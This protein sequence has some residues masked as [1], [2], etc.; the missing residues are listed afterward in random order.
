MAGINENADK[1]NFSLMK[2]SKILNNNKFDNWFIGYGTLLGIVRNNSCIDGDDDVDIICNMNDYQKL[3]EI[4]LKEKYELDFGHGINQ[5]KRIIKT[6]ASS[7]SAS[8]DFYMTEVD[9]NG[10]FNDIWEGI[11]WSN[12]YEEKTKEFI[13][14][15][16]NNTTL[17]L[18][19]D[20]HRKLRKIYGIFWR[21][22]QKNKG[23]RDDAKKNLRKIYYLVLPESLRN[24][25]KKIIKKYN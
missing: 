20:F 17:N 10:N 5:S 9:H 15:T 1:L 3:R 12:C 13:K 8:L 19:A 7:E 6:K 2:I 23:I 4:L 18:P 16:W 11:F 21:I 14:L 24:N 25:L 22:P